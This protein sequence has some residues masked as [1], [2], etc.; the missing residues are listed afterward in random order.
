MTFFWNDEKHEQVRVLAAESRSAS[1]IGNILGCSRN[2]IIGKCHR[3]GVQLLN[4]KSP[5]GRPAQ[6][7]VRRINNGQK[8][9]PRRHNQAATPEDKQ[10]FQEEFKKS[11]KRQ[12]KVVTLAGNVKLIDLESWHCRWP[13]GIPGTVDFSF[14]GLKRDGERSY[15]ALH[16]NIAYRRS[17]NPG[18]SPDV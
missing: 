6:P 3:L 5:T 9:K 13:Q 2:A 10:L 15:C 4:T 1:E 17:S 8:L 14:C 16:C 12:E 7:R 11:L 18:A